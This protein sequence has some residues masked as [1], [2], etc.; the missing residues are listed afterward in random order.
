MDTIEFWYGFAMGCISMAIISAVFLWRAEVRLHK[1]IR[2]L[3]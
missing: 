3:S 2:K 1:L